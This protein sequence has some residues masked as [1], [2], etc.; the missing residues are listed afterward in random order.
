MSLSFRFYVLRSFF[1]EDVDIGSA[2]VG[3]LYK[4]S[5]CLELRVQKEQ[6]GLINLRRMKLHLLFCGLGLEELTDDIAPDVA[7]VRS[8]IGELPALP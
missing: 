6:E 3:N 8:L 2:L 1:C 4:K 7:Y 5:R